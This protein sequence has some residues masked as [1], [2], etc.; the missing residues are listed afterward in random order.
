MNYG[1][2]VMN[3]MVK[4]LIRVGLIAFVLGSFDAK[5][6]IVTVSDYLSGSSGDSWTYITTHITDGMPVGTEFTV[7][8]Q[9]Y[10]GFE[11]LFPE[12][13][14]TGQAILFE[15]NIYN[16]YDII[17]SLTVPAGTYTNVLRITTLDSNFVANS[18]NNDLGIDPT[19]DYG[20]TDIGWLA[21]G[22]GEIKYIG[23]MAEN[24]DIDG[25]TELI[26]Y[27]PS[28][29][30]VPPAIWLLSSGLIGLIGVARRKKS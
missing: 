5:A 4:R 22:V 25:G 8:Q 11:E 1:V 21:M 27:S 13:A 24:G 19:I 10:M 18:V 17:D 7:T 30:P 3:K 15:A 2:I 23:V 28:V 16:Y 12:T 6:A 29:V 26:N 14:Q 20:V 9:F